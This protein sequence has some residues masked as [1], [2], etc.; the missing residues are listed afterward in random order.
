MR[1]VALVTG[2]S[3][4][5]G[6]EIALELAPAY[7]VVVN[8]A[9]DDVAAKEV[10]GLIEDAGG[11]AI[12]VR[13]DVG[14]P[15]QVEEMFAV[16]DRD[17]GTVTALVN[18]AGRRRDASSLTMSDEAFVEVLTV[19][20][21]GPFLCSKQALRRMLP[22]RRGHIVNVA[23]VAG[24]R[25]SPGQANY[26]ASKAGLIGMTRTMAV[27]VGKR[28]ITVNAVAPGLVETDLTAELSEAQVDG[29]L[30]QTPLGRPTTAR[31]VARAVSFLCSPQA[32]SINGSVLVIDGGMTA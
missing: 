12:A 28:G 29:L 25:G 31:E 18:N 21:V 16:I 4:G 7:P 8:F 32:T 1:E 20:L 10:V 2:A 15:V 14:D 24:L 26:S 6:K 5:I 19:N 17:F 22:K 13:C 30:K 9:H 23:S 27:E 11:E 3:R